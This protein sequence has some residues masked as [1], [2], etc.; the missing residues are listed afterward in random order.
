M[1]SWNVP[2]NCPFREMV[3]RMKGTLKR[4]FSCGDCLLMGSAFCQQYRDGDAGAS[5]HQ[6][7]FLKLA[8]D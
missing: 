1:P 6:A 4:D 3:K 7:H 2:S 5:L 8:K